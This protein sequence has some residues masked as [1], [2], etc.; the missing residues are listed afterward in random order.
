MHPRE[1][2]IQY[3]FI[4]LLS[5]PL[6]VTRVLFVLNS[7]FLS[8]FP[9]FILNLFTSIYNGHYACIYFR[10]YVCIMVIT[11]LSIDLI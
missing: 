1:S 5:R 6:T 8:F 2:Q 3:Y 7:F 11:Y 10:V 4:D 9:S